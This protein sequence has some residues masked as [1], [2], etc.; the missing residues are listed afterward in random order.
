MEGAAGTLYE[1]E[2]FQ[3]QFKFSP[4]YPFDSPEV[5]GMP[6]EVSSVSVSGV[7]IPWFVLASFCQGGVCL[8]R[9]TYASGMEL[10][11]RFAFPRFAFFESLKL[12]RHVCGSE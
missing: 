7:T 3:L 1:G 4:K 8:R 10:L 12:R 2:K 9:L 5:S 11:L 6:P